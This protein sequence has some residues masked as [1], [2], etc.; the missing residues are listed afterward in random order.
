MNK[1]IQQKLFNY[2]QQEHNILLFNG[3]YN[4]IEHILESKLSSVL[5][6]EEIKTEAEKYA[7]ERHS[8]DEVW[9]PDRCETIDGFIQGIRFLMDK[10]TPIKIENVTGEPQPDPETTITGEADPRLL[11]QLRIHWKWLKN[12]SYKEVAKFCTA[13]RENENKLKK[14]F[15]DGWD[16]CAGNSHPVDG[17][18]IQR[19]ADYDK[20][21]K[22]GD[23]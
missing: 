12:Q 21:R 5:T 15:L 2:F 18:S 22:G 13:F 6:N 16:A 17:A 8:N 1:D 19:I 7:I 4:E 14:A 9:Q 20:W 11:N 3:D 10:L 23:K